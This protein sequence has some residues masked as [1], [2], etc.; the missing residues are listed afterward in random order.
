LEEE[1]GGTG[2]GVKVKLD[3]VAYH[4]LTEEKGAELRHHIVA[5]RA[6]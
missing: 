1:N 2:E 4:R 5:C 3:V 6:E